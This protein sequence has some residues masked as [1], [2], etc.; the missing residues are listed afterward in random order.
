MREFACIALLAGL[1]TSG[2]AMARPGTDGAAPAENPP[3]SVEGPDDAESIR[4][5]TMLADLLV[6]EQID[7]IDIEAET[8]D[9]GMDLVHT[10]VD[11]ILARH[12]AE[13]PQIGVF[14]DQARQVIEAL[15][16]HKPRGLTTTFGQDVQRLPVRSRAE[17]R[18]LG[19]LVAN[20]VS[21][22]REQVGGQQVSYSETA[23]KLFR[24]VILDVEEGS[25]L[26]Q[27]LDGIQLIADQTPAERARHFR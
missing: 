24:S 27:Y 21:L 17:A 20:T 18:M 16:S 5:R 19:R 14:A 26:G 11:T 12:P 13:P 7:R 25:F 6:S 23:I 8:Y 9:Q 15:N 10:V 22:I 3:S 1:V 2:P 4:A